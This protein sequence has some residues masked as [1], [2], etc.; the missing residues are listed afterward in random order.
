MRLI[1]FLWRLRQILCQDSVFVF[2]IQTDAILGGTT[3][4]NTVLIGME[5]SAKRAKDGFEF[6]LIASDEIDLNFQVLVLV[7]H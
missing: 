4:P 1:S 7:L 6:D 3:V 5:E 2:S